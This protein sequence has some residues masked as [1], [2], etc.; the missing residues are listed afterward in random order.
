MRVETS[1]AE[2][3]LNN[4][5]AGRMAGD[6]EVEDTPPVMTDHEEAFFE[7]VAATIISDVY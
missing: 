4:P 1:L 7:V 3:L 2:K 6:V 5:G